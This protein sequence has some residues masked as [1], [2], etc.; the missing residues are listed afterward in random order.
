MDIPSGKLPWQWGHLPFL[1]VSFPNT[2]PVEGLLQLTEPTALRESEVCHSN[3]GEPE[4]HSGTFVI[5]SLD[6][7]S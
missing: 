1:D 6:H 3:G 4:S 2:P 5:H 7:L